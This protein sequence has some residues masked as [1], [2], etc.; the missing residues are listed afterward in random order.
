MTPTIW[1]PWLSGLVIFLLRI[2]DVSTGTLRTLYVVRGNRWLAWLLGFVQAMVFVIAV[3]RAIANLSNW[4]NLLGYAGGYATGTVVG[5]WL[6]EQLA[7]GY[8]HL[9]IVSP[10]QGQALAARLREAGFAVTEIAAR[11]RDGA[12]T[13]L[14]LSV[15]RRQIPEIRRIVSQTDPNAFLTVEDIR[16][17]RR[18]Y[19]RP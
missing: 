2:V 19:F 13:L 16:P 18:G 15:T 10:R 3:Q 7:V 1:A 6:E 14:S 8:A 17:L 5:M 12:V 11:G 4:W 9:R